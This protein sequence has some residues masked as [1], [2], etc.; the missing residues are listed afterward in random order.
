MAAGLSDD[1]WRIIAD[2]LQAAALSHVSA[3]LWRLLRGRHVALLVWPGGAAER[4]WEDIAAHEEAV[5]TLAVTGRRECPALVDILLALPSF[6][7]VKTLTL[8]LNQIVCRDAHLVPLAG[9]RA[10]GALEAFTLLCRGGQVGDNG[11]GALA[12]LSQATSLRHVHVDLAGNRAVGFKSA[13]T[14]CQLRRLP[15]L[16]SLHVDL[17]RTAVDT[18]GVVCL[19]AMREAPQLQRLH[20]R[21]DECHVLEPGFSSLA[22]LSQAPRLHTIFLGVCRTSMTQSG[23]CHL[24]R[25]GQ[26]ATI[27]TLTVDVFGGPHPPV[28]LKEPAQPVLSP[29]EPT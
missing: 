16:T 27:R 2:F 4:G 20:L 22:Y 24:S 10:L 8:D 5:Q 25:L 15:A 19:S 14:L 18:G 26:C 29:A 23:F 6:S 21:F 13:H 1:V 28:R 17:S 9:L 3:G 11:V 7:S 12:A